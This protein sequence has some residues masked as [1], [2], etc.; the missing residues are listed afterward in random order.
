MKDR[1][2]RTIVLGIFLHEGRLLVFEGYDPIRGITFYRPLGGGVEFGEYG[3][4]AL[5]REMREEL[6]AEITDV[7]YLGMIQSIFTHLGKQGHEIVLLYAACFADL[8]CYRPDAFPCAQDDG[9]PITAL[10]KPLADFENSAFLVPVELLPMLRDITSQIESRDLRSG[11]EALAGC[12]RTAQKP[13]KALIPED[14]LNI[15]GQVA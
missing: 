5:A 8:A 11:I 7:R 2:I 13:A 4:D 15:H 12:S 3:H 9:M 6:G 10:W 1:Q 14:E